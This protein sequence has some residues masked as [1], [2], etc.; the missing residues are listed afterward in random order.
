MKTLI[1]FFGIL[2]SF[3]SF[4]QWRHDNHFNFPTSTANG[5][6]RISSL[7]ELSAGVKW[8]NIY[9][10]G[11]GKTEYNY[12]PVNGGERFDKTLALRH[13]P[14]S[15]QFQ[16]LTSKSDVKHG[17][18]AV[19]HQGTFQNSYR[20]PLDPVAPSTEVQSDSEEIIQLS[21]SITQGLQTDM[22]KTK[23]IHDWVAGN[24]AY[25]VD[26]YF[27]GTYVSKS[28][29]ALTVLRKKQAICFGY[30]N[31]TAA[32]NRAAG[33]EARVIIGDANVYQVGW[34]AHAWNKVLVDGRWVSMDVTWDAGNVNFVKKVFQFDLKHKYFDPSDKDFA[35]DHRETGI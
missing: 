31:L 34:T 28:W 27:S 8:I 26:A 12:Y 11:N 35:L 16:I 7:K 23:A 19:E 13:G 3:S 22:E 4:A 24:I 18:Y 17:Q 25:D 14:G 29:D 32:L 20:K 15:Y 9:I 30:S 10:V 33:I 2:L 21:Q 6:I 5:Y 1:L